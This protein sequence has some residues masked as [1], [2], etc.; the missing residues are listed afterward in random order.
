MC[1]IKE[2]SYPCPLQGSG[3]RKGQVVAR[4]Q[5]LLCLAAK[6]RGET[7]GQPQED[8]ASRKDLKASMFQTWGKNLVGKKKWTLLKN[9]PKCRF[10]R[11]LRV[12]EGLGPEAQ[13]G[14]W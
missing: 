7:R 12:R 10:L 5:L 6:G 14:R 4:S 3:K 11:R 8:M 9:T 1:F 2:W 13:L